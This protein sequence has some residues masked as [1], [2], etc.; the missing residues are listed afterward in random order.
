MASSGTSTR[1]KSIAITQIGASDSIAPSAVTRTPSA[2]PQERDERDPSVDAE[3]DRR[4]D[5]VEAEDR[6]PGTDDRGCPVPRHR[7]KLVMAPRTPIAVRTSPAVES[8]IAV[9]ATWWTTMLTEPT[10][11]TACHVTPKS[12][13]PTAI[14]GEPSRSI[15][16]PNIQIGV[17]TPI[18]PNWIHVAGSR[19]HATSDTEH[20]EHPPVDRHARIVDLGPDQRP[21]QH[22]R[23]HGE[24]AGEDGQPQRSV[25]PCRVEGRCRHRAR[26]RTSVID[27]LHCDGDSRPAQAPTTTTTERGGRTAR[28]RPR[29]P[30]VPD[31]VRCA[32]SPT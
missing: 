27:R 9:P 1:L 10:C 7:S 28:V 30:P 6:Q 15:P 25:G 12:A 11:R 5:R 20:R 18:G 13:I 32:R 23:K 4:H 26:V 22:H 21:R 2:A 31:A 14:D 17:T 3:R 8:E 16:N 24:H 29:V 19:S